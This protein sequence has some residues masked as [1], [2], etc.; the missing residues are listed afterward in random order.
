M[1]EQR[2]SG[3]TRLR[4]ERGFALTELLIGTLLALALIGSA[5]GLF[6]TSVRS[7]PRTSDRAG[8]I[9][10]ARVFAES[11][12]RELRQGVTVAI[13]SPSQLEI[14]TYVKRAS[15][16]GTTAGSAIA[17]Q[18]TYTCSSGACTRVAAN[19]DGSAPGPAVQVVAGLADENVFS[20]SP[21]A[22]APTY[23][24]IRLAIEAAPGEDAITLEDGVALR[25]P[26]PE[27]PPA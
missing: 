1:A 9:G 19:V 23:V 17:C 20:Y 4:D 12:S 11:L 2:D 21:D 6:V 3:A 27:A 10:D 5:V 8:D 15:C 7:Q 24:G 14:V 16:G 18:V 25:N 13:A 26:A 22:V